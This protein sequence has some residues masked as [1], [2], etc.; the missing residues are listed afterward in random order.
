MKRTTAAAGALATALAL[1]V[2]AAAPAGAATGT[3][4]GTTAPTVQL[5]SA[6]VETYGPA[7]TPIY[8]KCTTDYPPISD[9]GYVDLRLTLTG[10]DAFGGVVACDD[11]TSAE[12]CPISGLGSVGSRGSARM[13][14]AVACGDD[15]RPRLVKST[16]PI[17][18]ATPYSDVNGYTRIDS[19][20]AKL[21]A[22]L[23]F[24]TPAEY[25][26]CGKRPTTLL[27]AKVFGITVGFDGEGG[28]PDR[29]FRVPGIFSWA[30]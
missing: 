25:G 9:C 19:N 2:A 21:V 23:E 1:T 7:D 30:P 29:T 28:T 12:G 17:L 3:T 11:E 13:H 24:P 18:P 27:H 15:P 5:A 14:A 16:L 10:F 22:T 8:P 6:Q 4:T 26:V 20:S